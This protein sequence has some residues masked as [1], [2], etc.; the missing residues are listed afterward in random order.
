MVTVGVESSLV[1]KVKEKQDQDPILVDLNANVHKQ[2]VLVFKKGEDSV[3]KYQGRL[4]VPEVD[5]LRGKSLEK[6]HGSRYSIHPGATKM[7]RDLQE[8]Y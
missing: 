1:S 5:N 2:R 4:C 3:I 8:V 6:A 7:Y